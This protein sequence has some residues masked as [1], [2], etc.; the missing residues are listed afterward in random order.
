M[1]VK[2]MTEENILIGNVTLGNFLVFIFLFIVTIFAGNLAYA[3]VRRFLD[4]KISIRNS[5]TISR[6]AEYGVL[7]LGLFYGIY[8]VLGLDFTAL[9]ASLGILTIAIAFSSQQIIQNF[10]AGIF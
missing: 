6:V 1:G 2:E 9:V 4:N 5:K 3:L 10:I 8:H 7:T